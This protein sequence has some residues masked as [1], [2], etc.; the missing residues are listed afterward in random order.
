MI[1]N[2]RQKKRLC[3][4]VYILYQH[5]VFILNFILLLWD[6]SQVVLDSILEKNDEL[7]KVY[8]SLDKGW[9][10]SKIDG[11]LRRT[12]DLTLKDSQLIHQQS[13]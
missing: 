5:T 9:M 8:H 3:L 11:N 6:L 13:S 7:Q 2:Q 10:T 12:L 1:N 4:H